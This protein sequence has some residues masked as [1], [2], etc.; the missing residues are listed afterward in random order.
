MSRWWV[1]SSHVRNKFC[2]HRHGS[3]GPVKGHTPYFGTHRQD[4]KSFTAVSTIWTRKSLP[5]VFCDSISFIRPYILT[6]DPNL[7]RMAPST[8]GEPV[9]SWCISSKLSMLLHKRSNQNEARLPPYLVTTF[10]LDKRLQWINFKQGSIRV[11]R[12]TR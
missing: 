2:L 12:V 8:I 1:C 10:V 5:T 9:Q 11:L 4:R 6:C 3:K 7:W